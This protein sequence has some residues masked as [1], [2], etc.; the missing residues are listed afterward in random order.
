MHPLGSICRSSQLRVAPNVTPTNHHSVSKN[1]L[2]IS[3]PQPPENKGFSALK[4]SASPEAWLSRLIRAGV[5]TKRSVGGGHDSNGSA[6]YY[7]YERIS[8]S[9]S[10]IL[11]LTQCPLAEAAA[12][13]RFPMPQA[14]RHFCARH[15]FPA[16]KAPQRRRYARAISYLFQL[17]IAG[18]APPKDALNTP[19]SMALSASGE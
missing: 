10:R 9:L 7:I 3:P 14:N 2:K 15:Y 1:Y 18:K 17:P 5:W 6:L 4:S 19:S 11:V 13:K 8:W 16:G 12:Q